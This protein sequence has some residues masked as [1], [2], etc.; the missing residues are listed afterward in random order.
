VTLFDLFPG[1]GHAEVFARA[2]ESHDPGLI[3]ELLPFLTSPYAREAALAVE[4][5]IQ[6]CAPEGAV[7]LDDVC[8]TSSWGLAA[9]VWDAALRTTEGSTPEYPGAVAVATCHASGFLRERALRILSWVD[10][11]FELPFLLIRL[12]DWVPP[13]RFAPHW[14]RCLGLVERVSRGGRATHT[15]LTSAVD[16]LLRRPGCREAVLLGLEGGTVA[17]RR[18]CMRIA[19]DFEDAVPHLRRALRDP[20]PAV[21]H[22]AAVVLCKVLDGDALREVLAELRRGGPRVRT[23]GLDTGCDRLPGE[24]RGLLQEA[25]M[26]PAASVRELARFRWGK[27]GF[28]G[29]GFRG[30]YREMLAVTT[31]DRFATALRGLAETGIMEDVPLFLNHVGH[32][33][34]RVREAAIL[35]LGRCDGQN[36]TAVLAGAV[37]DTNLSVSKVARRFARLY[38]GRQA[39]PKRRRTQWT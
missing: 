17:A 15:W 19:A 11:G 38:L 6:H 39:V 31:G 12:N 3:V 28:G 13:V 34:A 8:R 23:L 27:L 30:F 25:L 4:S 20:D 36:H 16:A 35:G 24:A 2:A 33:S 9:P 29:P 10:G 37:E 18:A 1:V 5:I 22:M 21:N 26:D 32:R 7:D 14:V